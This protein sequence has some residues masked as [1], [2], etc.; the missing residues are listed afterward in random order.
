MVYNI[1]ITVFYFLK[2]PVFTVV[3][4]CEKISCVNL[5]AS[6]DLIVSGTFDGFLQFIS[7]KKQKSLR[8]IDLKNVIP[9]VI[10][11]TPSWG[12]VLVYGLTKKSKKRV[13]SLLTS[14]GLR[15]KQIEIDEAL[16]GLT[17]YSTT[18][19]FDYAIIATESGKLYHFEVF[20][21]NIGESFYQSEFPIKSISYIKEDGCIFCTGNNNIIVSIPLSSQPT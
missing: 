8:V 7:I 16:T 18:S 9:L 13:L 14:N 19:G 6:F 1:N 11:I 3:T 12:F 5:S 15:I 21:L 4:Y 17:V 2:N 10:K 20:F